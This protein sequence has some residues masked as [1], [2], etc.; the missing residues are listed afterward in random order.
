MG[1][2]EYWGESVLNCVHTVSVCG[3]GSS[4]GKVC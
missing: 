2:G 3:R 4:G 1:G